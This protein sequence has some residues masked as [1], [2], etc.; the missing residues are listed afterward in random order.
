MKSNKK[1]IAILSIALSIPSSIAFLA[2]FINELVDKGI[3]GF[4]IGFSIFLLVI[5][6][7]IW[8]M[9]AYAFNKKD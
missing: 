1:W 3:I 9:V 2:L 6:G 7:M 5:S 8:L 4:K